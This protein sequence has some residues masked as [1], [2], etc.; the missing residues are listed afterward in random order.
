[1]FWTRQKPVQT[2]GIPPG[3]M[4]LIGALVRLTDSILAQNEELHD[5]LMALYEPEAFDIQAAADIKK[6]AVSPRPATSKTVYTPPPDTAV[7]INMPSDGGVVR[8]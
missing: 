2:A 7:E 1:V 5:R 4:A 3:G 6:T 8:E